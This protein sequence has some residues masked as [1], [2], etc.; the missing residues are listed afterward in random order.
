MNEKRDTRC[1]FA[2]P[3]FIAVEHWHPL[4]IA[5]TS[6]MAMDRIAHWIAR[7]NPVMWCQWMQSAPSFIIHSVRKRAASTNDYVR[8]YASEI[9]WGLVIIFLQIEPNATGRAEKDLP[10]VGILRCGDPARL[11]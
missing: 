9:A 6:I 2:Q 4:T 8:N 1:G 11:A 10:P 5:H 7:F 3:F